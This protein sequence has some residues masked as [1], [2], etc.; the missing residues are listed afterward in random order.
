MRA[1]AEALASLRARDGLSTFVADLEQVYDEFSFGAPTP[2][3]IRAFVAYAVKSS[4]RPRYVV[5]AGTGTVDYRGIEI[6]PG[7]VPPMMVRTNDGLFASDTKIAD[8]NNNGIPDVAIGRIPV[9]TT[10][11][12]LAYVDKLRYHTSSNATNPVIFSADAM[13]QQTDFGRASD[14]SALA[15]GDRP[16]VRLHI[17]DIGAQAARD[18]LMDAWQHGTPLVNWIGHGGV[19]QIAN[20]G[21]LTAGDAPALLAPGRL[22]ILVAMTCTIN[23]FEDGLQEPLGAALTRQPNGGALAVWSATGVSNH[24]NARELQR[25][26]MRLAAQKPQLRVGELIVLTHVA[27]PSD[28]AGIYVLLGDPAVALELPKETT[29]GGTPSSTG[30]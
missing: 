9:S 20:A 21:I 30:E 25:T 15:M 5:L 23:R 29:N 13:D 28:T 12:L 11:E 27:H 3:A 17:D 18:G 1:G 14:E 26:F 24:E 10:A 6:S 8:A 2:H 7:P 22:P 16:R 19:D 4:R